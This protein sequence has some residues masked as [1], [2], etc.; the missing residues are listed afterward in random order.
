[1][2]EPTTPH[3]FWRGCACGLRKTAADAYLRRMFKT[4]EFCLPTNAVKVPAGL[5]WLHEI[6]QD[7]SRIG[8]ERDGD[9]VQLITRGGYDW[10]TALKSKTTILT[11]GAGT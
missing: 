3:S 6:K 10:P 5:E 8:I 2:F 9:R 7:G 4:F 11:P 1:M